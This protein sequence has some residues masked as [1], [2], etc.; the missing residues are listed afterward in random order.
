[1]ADLQGNDFDLAGGLLGPF[2]PL[3]ETR[4]SDAQEGLPSLFVGTA[5]PIRPRSFWYDRHHI[6]GVPC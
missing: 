5:H 4:L 6:P 2:P 1:M 3:G